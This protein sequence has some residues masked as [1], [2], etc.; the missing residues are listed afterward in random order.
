MSKDPTPILNCPSTS[1]MFS[2]LASSFFFWLLLSRS[3]LNA[4]NSVSLSLKLALSYSI[5]D[6]LS[7]MYEKLPSNFYTL[8]STS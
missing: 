6:S 1:N 2:G 5:L 3:A 4:N 8:V 7:Y